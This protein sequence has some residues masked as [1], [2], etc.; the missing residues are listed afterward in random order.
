MRQI[1]EE[2]VQERRDKS[3][4]KN[5]V[6]ERVPNFVCLRSAATN[7]KVFLSTFGLEK[8]TI[9]VFDKGFHKFSL[10]DQ[11]GREGIFYVTRANKNAGYEVIAQRVLSDGVIFVVKKDMDIILKYMDKKTKEIKTTK[12]RLVEYVDP[13]SGRQFS[14]QTSACIY[15][16]SNSK[17]FHMVSL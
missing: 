9:A 17:N 3:I 10:Y 2:R 7:E 16:S 5:Y 14:W 1:A 4:Y 11:W 15:L 12:A 6:S 8:A 13:A